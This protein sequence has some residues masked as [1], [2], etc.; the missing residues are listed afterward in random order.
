MPTSHKPRINGH[1][2]P[3]GRI[4]SALRPGPVIPGHRPARPAP[5]TVTATRTS[6]AWPGVWAVAVLM[7]VFMV[8]V[9]SNTGDV[10]ISFAGV[11]GALPLAIA[12]LGALATGVVITLILGAARLTQMLPLTRKRPR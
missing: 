7:I 6:V 3:T 8:V 2:G 4:G 11:G 5:P 1:S 10:R 9:V 12:L